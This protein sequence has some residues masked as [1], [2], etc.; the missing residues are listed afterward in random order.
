MRLSR[1]LPRPVLVTALTFTAML[2]ASLFAAPSTSA[3]SI[4]AD[5]VTGVWL[6]EEGDKGGRARVEVKREGDEFVGRIIW[7]EE[8]EFPPGDSNAGEP[9]TDLEN[10]DEEL[11]DRPII[12]LPI[13]EGMTYDGD[14]TWDGGTIYDPANGKTYKAKMSL[15]SADDPTLDVRGFIGFSLFGRTTTWKR[16]E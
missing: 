15:D 16:V 14:G 2:L 6:T 13:L 9:K 12:G 7:L 4:P 8:P 5:A 11:R 1:T 3:Q 10:P